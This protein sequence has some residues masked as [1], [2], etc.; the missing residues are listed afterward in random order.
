MGIADLASSRLYV[1]A[2][3]TPEQTQR[4]GCV[5]S[6]RS[7]FRGLTVPT[8]EICSFLCARTTMD[9]ARSA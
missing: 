2:Q 4:S 8:S 3:A 1:Q 7:G 5:R 9:L 6:L